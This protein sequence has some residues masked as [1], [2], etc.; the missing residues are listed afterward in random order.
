M[1]N[2]QY[3]ILSFLV[4]VGC[5]KEQVLKKQTNEKRIALLTKASNSIY[6]TPYFNWEDSSFIHIVNR[7]NYPLPWIG[8]A[9]NSISQDILYDYHHNDGWE[10]V[11][12][13]CS[14]TL[15]NPNGDKNY[16]IL[17]NKIRG[18]LR[19][20]CY[21]FNNTSTSAKDSYA[22]L[23]LSSSSRL[24]EFSQDIIASSPY[25][26]EDIVN[27][28]NRTNNP[29]T[30]AL[31]RGWNCFEVE[32]AYDNLA[33]SEHNTFS[34]NIFDQIHYNL[35]LKGILSG[36]AE[37]NIIFPTSS[38][39]T[40]QLQQYGSAAKNTLNDINDIINSLKANRNSLNQTEK[41][42]SE[43]N[44][45]TRTIGTVISIASSSIDILT[46][47]Y[48]V[49]ENILSSGEEQSIA[50]NNLTIGLD[51]DIISN[52]SIAQPTANVSVESVGNLLLPGSNYGP[53]DTVLPH[54]NHKLGAW[55]IVETPTITRDIEYTPI[56]YEV[57]P[58][59]PHYNH[60]GVNHNLFHIFGD[61]SIV[62][63]PET[64]AC[65]D[66]YDYSISYYYLYKYDGNY[67]GRTLQ[68]DELSH[69]LVYNKKQYLKKCIY[70]ETLSNT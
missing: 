70:E 28:P 3:I 15:L 63:N 25:Q 30:S 53:N 13:I 49:F 8:G 44:V 2:I 24:F 6:E 10:L 68:G 26:S 5:A 12:N 11:Y 19:I 60:F 52:G 9:D 38:T 43:Q 45:N 37:G 48:G 23:L 36:S 35:Q 20:Y 41:V 31:S 56:V 61:I 47:L 59:P 69:N 64:L 32:L 65:I 16:L 42:E 58:G 17:Y 34:I 46:T 21:N 27:L 51:A 55:N 7:G 18:I 39:G 62:I 57:I 67:V 50:T 66:S 54:Y 22:Q 40:P 4:I 1:K 14:D 33:A 29:N